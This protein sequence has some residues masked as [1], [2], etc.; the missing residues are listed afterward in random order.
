MDPPFLD[1]CQSIEKAANKRS[2]K[3]KPLPCPVFPKLPPKRRHKSSNNVNMQDT[4]NLIS[5]KSQGMYILGQN[6]TNYCMLD[7]PPIG[8]STF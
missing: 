8:L 1:L 5:L 6:K 7:A 2:E 4:K 3:T